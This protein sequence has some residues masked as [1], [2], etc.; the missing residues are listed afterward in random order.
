MQ[1]RPDIIL[2]H[3][4]SSLLVNVSKIASF[5][6]VLTLTLRGRFS[7]CGNTKHERLHLCYQN[8]IKI[9]EELSQSRHVIL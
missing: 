3:V 9:V 5:R 4:L 8:G 2:W 7:N 6:T 1:N